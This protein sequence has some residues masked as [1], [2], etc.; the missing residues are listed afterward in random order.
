MKT[1]A[2]LQLNR[3]AT[4]VVT[5]FFTLVV[6]WGVANYIIFREVF[7]HWIVLAINGALALTLG[8]LFY[9][10]N[11]HA[12]FSYDQDGF[13]IQVGKDQA[14]GRW[15]DFSTVSLVHRGM[16]EYAVRVYRNEED[17]FEIPA[18][19]L[20]LDPHEFRFEVIQLVKKS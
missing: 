20:K 8:W 3:F 17:F 9:K 5:L 2:P 14:S 10:N 18:S 19:A 13:Q 12:I 11:R 7:L 15:S 16:G 6:L 4:T 1:I